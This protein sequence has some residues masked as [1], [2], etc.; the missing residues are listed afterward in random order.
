MKKILGSLITK[1]KVR[2][3][4]VDENSMSNPEIIKRSEAEY[5]QLSAENRRRPS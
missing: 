5:D 2:G 4:Y 3:L 1:S